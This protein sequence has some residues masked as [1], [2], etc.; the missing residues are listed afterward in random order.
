MTHYRARLACIQVGRVCQILIEAGCGDDEFYMLGVQ[1]TANK[2][3]RQRIRS[4]D[5]AKNRIGS[6]F[7]GS[8][9]P[10]SFVGG[11]PGGLKSRRG[12]LMTL[13]LDR[14]AALTL[15]EGWQAMDKIIPAGERYP[16]S[17]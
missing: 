9:R 3:M 13:M 17:A 6:W 11:P 5:P 14:I 2:L 10:V 16:K 12:S 4:T 7:A 15:L 1:W 8:T